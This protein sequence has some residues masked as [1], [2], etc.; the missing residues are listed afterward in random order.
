MEDEFLIDKKLDAKAEIAQCAAQ[1]QVRGFSEA[2]AQLQ[3]QGFEAPP[4][5]TQ[6]QAQRFNPTPH[7]SPR[8]AD[9]SPAEQSEF[10]H[11]QM[12]QAQEHIQIV[13]GRTAELQQLP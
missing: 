2:A 12:L 13:A 4:D 8:I 3:S 11:E 6:L 9:K 7:L 1:L 5:A 10:L